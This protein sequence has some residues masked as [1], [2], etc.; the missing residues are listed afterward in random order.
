MALD[1]LKKL[2][3]GIELKYHKISSIQINNDN[4]K[5]H[6]SIKSYVD[7]N[8]RN[9]EKELTDKELRLKNL[10][11]QIDEENAKDV[12]NTELVIQLSSEYTE[13]QES[14]EYPTDVE[15]WKMDREKLT[16]ITE[17]IYEL[18]YTE[19]VSV[20]YIYDQLKLH[21][22]FVGSVDI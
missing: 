15:D 19:E 10:L 18:E 5:L 6:V 21:E 14:L 3:N 12:P 7:E 17:K 13:V 20:T 8:S 16:Y 9:K 1:K 11:A 4:K 22:D 2:Y